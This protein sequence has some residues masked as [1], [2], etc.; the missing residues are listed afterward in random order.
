MRS[1]GC[2]L[3]ICLLSAPAM[4]ADVTKL[5]LDTD[6]AS[7][8]GVLDAF[9]R[10]SIADEE[11]KRLE[12]LPGIR[13]MIEQT[14]RFSTDATPA[15]FES[16]LRAAIAHQPLAPEQD[17]F[18]FA[19]LTAHLSEVQGLMQTMQRDPGRFSSDVY[20]RLVPYTPSGLDLHVTVHMTL[21]GTSDGWAPGDKDF[22]LSLNHFDGDYQGLVVLTSHEV[23]HLVQA[24]L[25]PGP[26]SQAVAV[27][28]HNTENILIETYREGS[29]TVVGDPTQVQ[30]GGKWIKWFSGKYASNADHLADDYMLLDTMLYRAAH[31]PGVDYD[32]LYSLGFS[33]GLGSA[34]YFVGYN[35]AQVIMAYRGRDALAGHLARPARD[36]F[37]D[38]LD[39]CDAHKD[40]RRCLRFSAEAESVMRGAGRAARH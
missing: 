39:V 9:A 32:R 17:P 31:D 22:Y 15:R 36:F 29:A 16:S 3:L 38:Y 24:K 21:G 37:T 6:Y 7:A 26:Q 27:S 12:S 10:G 19:A 13:E 23:Y 1:A 18:R 28:Q 25:M 30:D 33:G 11:L 14:G 35:M 2:F 4:A 34:A 5:S 40:D 20:R 8:Q